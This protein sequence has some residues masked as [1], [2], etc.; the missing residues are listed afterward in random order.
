MSTTHW[1]VS[2]PVQ[3]AGKPASPAS[4][5]RAARRASRYSPG[6]PEGGPSQQDRRGVSVLRAGSLTHATPAVPSSFSGLVAK[7]PTRFREYGQQ[8]ETYPSGLHLLSKAWAER[9]TVEKSRLH[10][11]PPGAFVS[12]AVPTT[13]MGAR[14]VRRH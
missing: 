3:Q 2:F 7:L 13:N 11:E 9:V 5:S 10:L 4:S 14:S 1:L 6:G 12:Y 8:S